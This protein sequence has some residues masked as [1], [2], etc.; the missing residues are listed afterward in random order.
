MKNKYPAKCYCCGHSCGPGDGVVIKYGHAW[1]V[2][3][4][5]CEPPGGDVL[6][7]EVEE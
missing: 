7:Y 6:Y 3:H 5:K 1:R 4:D 2:R